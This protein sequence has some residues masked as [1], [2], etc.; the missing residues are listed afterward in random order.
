MDTV[1]IDLTS[2]DLI[3]TGYKKAVMLHEHGKSLS[4]IPYPIPSALALGFCRAVI[5]LSQQAIS[6]YTVK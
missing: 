3:L 2:A 4:I 5:E 6:L 1:S